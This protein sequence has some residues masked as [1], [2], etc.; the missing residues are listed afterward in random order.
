MRYEERVPDE[1]IIDNHYIG[2]PAD[3]SDRIIQKRINLVRKI[4]NFI[5]KE[6]DLLEIGCGN[7][8]S[9]LLLADEMKNCLGIELFEGN[10]KEFD[11]LKK[12][13]NVNNCE[14][15]ILNI[16]KEVLK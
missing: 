15:R 3:F 13:L 10:K 11:V 12:K 9:M 2:R 16:E 4:P 8:A 14:F 7:G 1:L 6:S 5:S